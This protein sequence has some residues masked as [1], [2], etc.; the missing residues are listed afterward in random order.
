[1]CFAELFQSGIWN[2]SFS[3]FV[4]SSTTVLDTKKRQI[5]GDKPTALLS[6]QVYTYAM[7]CHSY[8][9]ILNIFTLDLSGVIELQTLAFLQISNSWFEYNFIWIRLIKMEF[10]NDNFKTIMLIWIHYILNRCTACHFGVCP[11][12]KSE[13]RVYWLTER[14]SFKA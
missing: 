4:I 5:Y 2:L 9:R 10:L 3:V 14:Q 1:M 12:I 13:Q 6:K 11:F 7:F 8:A